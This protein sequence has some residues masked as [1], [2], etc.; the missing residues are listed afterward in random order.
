RG[1]VCV[2][3]V[4]FFFQAED[5]IRD[6]NVTGVQTC[7][8]PIYQIALEAESDGP[9]R[10]QRESWVSLTNGWT[11]APAGLD[12]WSILCSAETILDDQ[13][14]LLESDIDPDEVRQMEQELIDAG[15][16][17]PSDSRD[18]ERNMIT[19]SLADLV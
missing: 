17:C 11:I 3:V 8:L 10:A 7:A 14:I 16:I 13:G 2:Y 19:L 6:R 5:G 9:A 15:Y 1:N 12:K 4:V 18:T